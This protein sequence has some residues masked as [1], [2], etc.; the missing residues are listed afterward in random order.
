[1]GDGE[2]E[3]QR[4][5]ET[6]RRGDRGIGITFPSISPSLHLSVPPSL[7]LSVSI[8]PSVNLWLRCLSPRM[9]KIEVASLI[10]LRDVSAEERAEATLVTRRRRRPSGAAARHLFFVDQQIQF[11]SRHVQ[12]DQISV[13]R[14]RQRPA[15]VTFWRDVQHAGAV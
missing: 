8:S 9:Q 12:F 5:R 1:M 7:R 10:G 13:A 11:S 4:D 15:D 2:T 3:E 6:E 14:E